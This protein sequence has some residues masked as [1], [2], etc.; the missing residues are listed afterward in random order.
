MNMQ[1]TVPK[2]ITHLL[3]LCF[4]SLI[5][6]T[7][8]T[9]TQTQTT[10]GS[11][12]ATGTG[13]VIQN[14]NDTLFKK[15][16]NII[17]ILGDDVGYEIPGYTGGQSYSTPNIDMMAHGGMQFSKCYTAPSCSPSRSMLLTGQYNFR[18]YTGWGNMAANTKTIATMMRD[19]GYETCMA[20][21]WQI[22]GG[23]EVP[24]SL[25]FTHYMRANEMSEQWAAQ[26]KPG[27][28]KYPAVFENGSYLPDSKTQ[29]KYGQ[30]LFRDYIFNF[31]DEYKNK[32]PF[33]V[34]WAMNLPHKP[35][36]PTPDDPDYASWPRAH[37]YLPGDTIYFP[38]MVKYMDKQIG[39]LLD[40][41]KTENMLENTIIIF[42]G[43]NGTD[44]ISSRWNG[45]I[46]QGRKSETNEYGTH[47]PMLVYAPGR[48]NA[49]T[50]DASLIDFTDFLPTFASIAGVSLPAAYF[51]DGINF[52]PRLKA[53]QGTPREWI[54]CSYQP[55][56]EKT[57]LKPK[58]WIQNSTYKKYDA[59]ANGISNFYNVQ[60]DPL[61]R[62]PITR[63]N[64]TA[65][66][67]NID[68]KFM[69]QLKSLQ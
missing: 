56:P 58:R 24:S 28:Y 64:M 8:K 3:V 47:V 18:N 29:G 12:T 7:C 6:F 50:T 31:I 65:A 43:D 63:A 42:A 44:H 59:N 2:K 26:G 21:K 35:F 17:F 39:Q 57:N 49:G 53:M 22:N 5:M 33:F 67:K 13:N 66:E 4:F 45:Q 34:Y 38:G 69:L 54:F 11:E 23:G 51:T 25:G 62:N 1:I 40:K 30:D 55:H 36:A 48:I 32:K 68:D 37:A 10:T 61:E 9:Q 19:A 41:L 52:A 16:T 46:V 20:G 14:S 15:G 27:Y 60:K